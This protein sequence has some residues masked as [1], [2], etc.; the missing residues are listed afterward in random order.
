MKKSLQSVFAALSILAVFGLCLF[1][2]A[3]GADVL[4]AGYSNVPAWLGWVLIS[5][6]FLS[7]VVI[8]I[9]VINAV[10]YEN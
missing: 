8:V 4:C 3:A 2:I 10:C 5:E 9:N 6:G 7:F 1:M